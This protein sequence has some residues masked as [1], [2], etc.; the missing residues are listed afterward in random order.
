MVTPA[1]LRIARAA[2]SLARSAG[3]GGGT[4]LPGLIIERAAPGLIPQLAARLGRG[5]VL[6]S[7]TNGK[8]TTCRILGD[9]LT[10]A[11]LQVIQNRAGSN[12]MR[13]IT[14]ALVNAPDASL[15]PDS[16]G[17]F[18]VDEATLPEAAAT[19]SPR[20][21]LLLNLFRDQLDRYGEVDAIVTRWRAMV[22][23]LP[24]AATV[25]LNADDPVVAALGAPP[26]RAAYFGV[27][28]LTA[29]RAELE[30]AADFTECAACGT[31]YDYAAG[32]FG[33]LGHYRCPHCG[34]S[35]PAAGVEATHVATAGL[36][37]T[38]LTVRTAA[39]PA[40][41]ELPLPGLYNVY[42]LLGALA[43]VEAVGVGLPGLAGALAAIRPA[44]GRAEVLQAGD[45]R[46]TTLL[47]KNPVGANQV[48][49][50]LAEEPGQ[51][52]LVLALN[53][54]VADGQDVS[55]IWDVDYEQLRGHVRLAVTTGR[56]AADMALRLKHAGWFEAGAELLVLPDLRQALETGLYRLLP[57][58]AL[59]VLP[60]YTAMLYLRTIMTGLGLSRPFWNDGEQ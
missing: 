60:T 23:A 31:P 52:T 16:I 55:W 13:G 47:T 59:Y 20:C 21:V 9:L 53:D 28:D 11:G 49:R 40:A 14:A 3:L 5:V 29:G 57:G 4:S 58:Q 18:E 17:V 15:G 8:T 56:R 54:G 10:G 26:V 39:G 6:V 19:L 51:K 46:V 35:R 38:Q 43:T 25:V 12:L 34:R 41:V 45:K 48:L 22:Q 1:L 44:F 42:N 7:G 27:A 32:F 36:G 37:P 24:S 50:S 30:H 33:H 2:G